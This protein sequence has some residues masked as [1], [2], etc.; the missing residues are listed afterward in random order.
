MLRSDPAAW[1]A[2]Q[3]S[4]NHTQDWQ[5]FLMIEPRSR[6]DETDNDQTDDSL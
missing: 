1:L 4:A 5:Y 6:S 2:I 3:P